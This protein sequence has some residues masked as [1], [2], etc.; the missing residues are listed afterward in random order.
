MSENRKEQYVKISVSE[1]SRLREDALTM[2]ALERGG[3]DNWEWY[4]D[5]LDSYAKNNT[6]Y[7]EWDDY[8]YD[9]CSEEYILKHYEKV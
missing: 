4:G 5:S 7:E 1:L 8:I 3:V 2:T 9:T 6:E